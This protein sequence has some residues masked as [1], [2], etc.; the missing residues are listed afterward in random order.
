MKADVV[1][2]GEGPA[3]LAASISSARN[4]AQT[5]LIERFNSIGG[6]ATAGL[7]GPFMPTAGE[8]GGVY[9]ELLNRLKKIDGAEGKSFDVESFK[10]A[11]QLMCEEAGVKF[12]LNSFVCDVI[13]E[14]DY[15]K[16]IIVANKSGLQAISA[17]I[18]IDTTGDGD[19]AFFAG[20]EYGKGDRSGKCQPTTMMFHIAGFDK[21]KVP[22]SC[23]GNRKKSEAGS[24]QE[25]N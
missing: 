6:M 4:G 14:W 21:S 2:C 1:V 3:G 9:K 12:L 24:K 20:A 19:A 25:R 11:V 5:L 23:G 10:Y 15:I 7:V 22:D 8:D 13:M 17:D 18:V 16:A